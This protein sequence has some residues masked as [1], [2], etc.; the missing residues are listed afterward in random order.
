MERSTSRF[1]WF[2]LCAMFGVAAL[3]C[4]YGAL[5]H[6]LFIPSRYPH[7]HDI[8]LSGVAAWAFL[9]GVI[10][11]WFG[12]AVRLG[13]PA[14]PRKRRLFCEFLLLALGIVLLAAAAGGY[15]PTLTAA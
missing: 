14:L 4:L 12:V 6:R 7:S 15:L 11:V 3:Y 8:A 10:A 2:L 13:F 9:S 1:D 5:R